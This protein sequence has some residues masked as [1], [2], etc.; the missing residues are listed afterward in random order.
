MNQTTKFGD[1]PKQHAKTTLY[2]TFRN[3]FRRHPL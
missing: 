3:R 2:K 1:K